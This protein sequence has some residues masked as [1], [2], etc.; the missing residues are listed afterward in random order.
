MKRMFLLWLI[1]IFA[2]PGAEP[3]AAQSEQYLGQIMIVGFNFCPKG[4]AIANGGLLHINQN[5][6]LFSLLGTR[7]GGNGTTTF[8]LPDLVETEMVQMES[9]PRHLRSKKT[10]KPLYCIALQGVYPSRH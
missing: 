7:Y 3:A 8:A 5:T 6:A 2:I 4:W 10:K 9:G 1:A